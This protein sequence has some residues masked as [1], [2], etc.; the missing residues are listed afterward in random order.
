[1]NIISHN[2]D[3]VYMLCKQ[4][5]TYQHRLVYIER[6]PHNDVLFTYYKLEISIITE[7][8]AITAPTAETVP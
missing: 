4:K 7:T 8:T 6:I 5:L 2:S 3:Y 1:M